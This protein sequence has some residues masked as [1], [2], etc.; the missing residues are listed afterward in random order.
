MGILHEINPIRVDYVRDLAVRHLH[1]DRYA[2]LPLKGFPS[3]I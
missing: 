1:R 3:P 2:A